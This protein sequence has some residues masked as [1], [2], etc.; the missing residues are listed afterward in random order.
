MKTQTRILIGTS[1]LVAV[2]GVLVIFTPF[3]N[4][5]KD[6]PV[7]TKQASPN[8]F[9]LININTADV[10]DIDKLPMIGP[11]KAKAIVDYRTSYGSFSQASDLLNVKGIGKSTLSKISDLITGFSSDVSYK[12]VS[13]PKIKINTATLEEIENLSSIGEVKAREIIS[14]RESH[15]PF[16]SPKDLLNVKGIGSKTLEKI[17]DLVDFE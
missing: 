12:N 16:H 11:S 7:A 3:K 1:I 15:G 10:K 9:K 17:Q 8:T 6:D 5:V 2:A 14:Y 4:L 13:K